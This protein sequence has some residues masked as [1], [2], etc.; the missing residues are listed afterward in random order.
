MKGGVA[1]EEEKYFGAKEDESK[2]E[3]EKEGKNG[4]PNWECA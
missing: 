4:R 2:N 1:R 3:E